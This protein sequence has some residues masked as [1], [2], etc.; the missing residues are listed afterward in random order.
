MQ[1]PNIEAEA[2]G[3][4]IGR[5]TNNA[6]KG[7]P[8]HSFHPLPTPTSA[9][10]F[11]SGR[12]LVVQPPSSDVPEP[13][14]SHLGII[15]I[16]PKDLWECWQP[17]E[18]SEWSRD[19][20]QGLAQQLQGLRAPAATP[21]Y[22]TRAPTSL[23]SRQGKQHSRS[24]SSVGLCTPRTSGH[25]KSP[26]LGLWQLHALLLSTLHPEWPTAPL[27]DPHRR[28]CACELSEWNLCVIPLQVI[29][30]VWK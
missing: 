28:D 16:C 1:P 14:C 27:C 12:G 24:L 20:T 26:L 30:E 3:Q 10:P 4:P 19:G 7:Q 18:G 2:N 21:L 23:A 15:C 25:Q 13:Y 5:P 17:S 6:T 11:R 9:S 22:T 8:S 29:F